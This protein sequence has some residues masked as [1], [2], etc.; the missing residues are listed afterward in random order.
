ME[1]AATLVGLHRDVDAALGL[2]R[3]FHLALADRE[4]R[5]VAAH[6]DAVARVPFGAALAHDDVA[7]NDALAARLLDPEP[8]SG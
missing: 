6:A 1:A 3:E 7:G 4:Q 5:V 8:P 2:G